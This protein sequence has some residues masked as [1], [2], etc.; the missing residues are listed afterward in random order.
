M[1]ELEKE[2]DDSK[3]L[4][5]QDLLD[6][7]GERLMCIK[8]N[9]I[10]D[11]LVKASVAVQLPNSTLCGEFEAHGEASVDDV[12]E[13]FVHALNRVAETR[14]IVRAL[15]LALRRGTPALAEMP[16][17]KREEKAP[18]AA[19]VVPKS[20]WVDLISEGLKSAENVCDLHRRYEDLDLE[21]VPEED[22][23]AV[24]LVFTRQIIALME[25]ET[26]TEAECRKL[27]E[28]AGIPLAEAGSILGAALRKDEP[29]AWIKH[30]LKER[31]AMKEKSGSSN[32]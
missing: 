1:S 27:L 5:L 10:D 22:A 2:L 32:A 14:A 3:Y 6:E 18:E 12:P 24:R 15:R 11:G 28:K 7:A 16:E 26:P 21:A 8:T 25:R 9:W 23:K 19:A 13:G 30:V 17:V 31:E 4:K 29:A 20:T